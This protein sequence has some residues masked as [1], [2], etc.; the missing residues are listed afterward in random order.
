MLLDDKRV[1]DEKILRLQ[2]RTQKLQAKKQQLE[3]Q[4]AEKRR[5]ELELER[6]LVA[7]PSEELRRSQLES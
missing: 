7:Q 4:E 5:R 1:T 2:Q 3:A 6:Q